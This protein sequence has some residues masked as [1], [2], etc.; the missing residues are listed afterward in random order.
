MSQTYTYTA[1]DMDART[2]TDSLHT[3]TDTDTHSYAHA[4]THACTR[5]LHLANKCPTSHPQA[6]NTCLGSRNSCRRGKPPRPLCVSVTQH[7]IG[8]GDV[9]AI[10]SS[11]TLEPLS[12]EQRAFSPPT[13]VR[14]DRRACHRHCCVRR[15]GGRRVRHGVHGTAARVSIVAVAEST[16]HSRLAR[17]VVNNHSK[18]FSPSRCVHLLPHSRLVKSKHTSTTV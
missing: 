8:R 18:S 17:R 4:R 10:A 6:Q 3:D 12:V 7:P 14:N 11:S 2:D 16:R 1:T 5:A 13:S 15:D 9:V